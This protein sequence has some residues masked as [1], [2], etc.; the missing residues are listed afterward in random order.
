MS[1]SER[2]FILIA[3][4]CSQLSMIQTLALDH[5]PWKAPHCAAFPP[6]MA[7][8]GVSQPPTKYRSLKKFIAVDSVMFLRSVGRVFASSDGGQP[9]GSWVFG[10]LVPCV[11]EL[12]LHLFSRELL[13]WVTSRVLRTALQGNYN[14]SGQSYRTAT[15]CLLFRGPGDPW[16]EEL[17][18]S[19]TRWVTLSGDVVCLYIV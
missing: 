8:M 17:S 4:R 10:F 7:A 18:S 12:F 3:S 6:I 14:A 19:T 5:V 2:K 16:N 13:T 11:F 15:L 9:G 1:A